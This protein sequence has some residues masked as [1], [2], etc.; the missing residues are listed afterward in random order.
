MSSCT[1]RVFSGE[2]RPSS[3]QRAGGPERLGAAR[4]CMLARRKC[5]RGREGTEKS[6][7]RREEDS[8]TV[9]PWKDTGKDATV[10]AADGTCGGD[11]GEEEKSGAEETAEETAEEVHDGGPDA[12]C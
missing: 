4:R 10:D 1:C 8:T 11:A 3:R 9:G 12:F 2:T 7:G 6:A 5:C